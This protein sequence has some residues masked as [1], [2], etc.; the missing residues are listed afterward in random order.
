M[1]FLKHSSSTSLQTATMNMDMER[2]RKEF[3]QLATEMDD[4]ASSNAP[5]TQMELQQMQQS[6][7]NLFQ[8]KLN[9]TTK[10]TIESMWKELEILIQ[11]Y[12]HLSHKEWTQTKTSSEILTNI[13]LP[14]DDGLTDDFK[15]MFHRVL[16]EGNWENALSHA[17][18][19]HCNS[20]Y[21]ENNN[22]NNKPWAVLVTGVNGIRKTTSIYQPWFPTLLQEALVSPSSNSQSAA[23]VPLSLLL[24]NGQ[25]SFFRQLDHMIA[26]ISNYNFQQ[27][28][29]FTSQ[30]HD[31]NISS[32]E[33]SSSTS[34]S[35]NP[36]SKEI[37]QLYSNYKASIFKRY[38]TLSEILGITLI[39]QAMK[40][41]LNVMIETS[42]RDV[43]MFHYIDMFFPNEEYNKLV[44]H[45]EINDLGCAEESVD[46]RMVREMEDGVK[47][48]LQSS[49]ISSDSTSDNKGGGGVNIRDL[50]N[51]NAGG[52]YGSEVLSG[53]Q[54]DSDAVWSSIVE[55]EGSDNDEPKK[56]GHDWFKASI[57]INASAN[58][59]W[60]ARAI[61]PNGD[62]GQVF[63]FEAPRQV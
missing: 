11:M 52:P 61:L 44:L 24:P 49:S 6:F 13:L 47:V 29:E 3:D 20:Q 18:Q 2:A 62:E 57:K 31:F 41:K 22:N 60:T 53:I 58:Q 46:K 12:G 40:Q 37:I 9:D 42:G 14:N 55:N 34:S 10:D 15:H 19:Q 48:L 54:R 21:A 63:T 33:S 51:V 56:V 25:N 8:D 27:L 17:Q 4:R 39:Q 45:F 28:Y 59:D 50:I 38:R 1:T 36:P 5:F 32:T 23:K 26:T 43:A 16:S 35:T 7:Y 30:S